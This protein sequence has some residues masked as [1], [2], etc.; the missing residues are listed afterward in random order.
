MKGAKTLGGRIL[1]VNHAGEHGAI[2]IYAGQIIA[3]RWLHRALLPE[4]IVFKGH[5][6]RHRDIFRAELKWRGLPRCR[7]YWLCVGGGMALGLVTGILGR[8]AI[9]ITTAAVE[10]VVLRHLQEQLRVLA[11]S[12]PEATAAIR[13]VIDD[14]QHH[15]DQATAQV[16]E[17][18]LLARWWRHRP[19]P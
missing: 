16:D 17:T 3:A 8:H 2:S 15:H 18:S 6:E 19:S 4:L 1:K 11:G 14:E 13:S 9:A 7:S 10:R 12:D 5:E